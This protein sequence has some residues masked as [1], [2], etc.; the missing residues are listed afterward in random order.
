MFKKCTSTVCH[1][2][3][4]LI[5]LIIPFLIKDTFLSYILRIVIVG[6]MIV[7]FWGYYK[8]RWETNYV[9]P[10]YTGI[11]IFIVWVGLEGYYPL[12]GP[13]TQFIP[14]S[15]AHVIAKL[16]G[17]VLLAPVIEE[18]FVRNYLHR[19]VIHPDYEKVKHGTFSWPAFILTT[20]F[21]GIAHNRWLV[22]LITG[23]LLNFVYYRHK[24]IGSCI[25][26]HYTANLCLAVFVLLT[27]AWHLW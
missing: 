23:V 6:G 5:Y 12:L 7:F 9:F 17:M 3:P 13:P 14:L 26:A 16:M 25:V 22:G 11:I 21:F 15:F 2:L 8:I 20:L 27:G 10:V 19:L 1:L 18:L 4:F 24:N